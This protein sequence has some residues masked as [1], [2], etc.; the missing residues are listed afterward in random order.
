M[1]RWVVFMHLFATFAFLLAHGVQAAVMLKFRREADPERSLALF[2]VLP[3][4][5]LLRILV[6]LGVIT[7]LVAGFMTNWW[8]QG[9]MWAS[10]VVLVVITVLMSRYGSG[11]FGLI[12]Q[13]A[14]RAIEEGKGGPALDEF[15]AVRGAWHPIGMTVFGMVGLAIILWLMMFKPF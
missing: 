8:R 3:S 2:N 7:G 10:L 4:L 14:A 6:A 11:Y 1:Y 15:T 5:H 12:Q 9:W 13:A